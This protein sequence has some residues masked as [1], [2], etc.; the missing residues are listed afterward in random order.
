M[1]VC[2]YCGADVEVAI[3]MEQAFQ[4]ELSPY[5]TSKGTLRFPLAQPMPTDLIRRIVEVRVREVVGKTK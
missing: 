5:R 2:L 3:A 4:E 1:E